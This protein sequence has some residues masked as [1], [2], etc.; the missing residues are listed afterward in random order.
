MTIF[1]ASCNKNADLFAIF[2]HCMEKYWTKHPKVVYSTETIKN[3]YYTTICKDYPLDQWTR[4]IRESLAEIDDDVIL[5]MVDDIFIRKAVDRKRIKFAESLFGGSLAFINLEQEFGECEDVGL[6]GFKR[7]T[8][9][10]FVISLM[11]GLWDREK[12]I[13]IL[14]ADASPWDVEFNADLKD[15]TYYINSGDRII[16]WGH[17]PFE[18]FGLM[19]G[20]W[21]RE[22][23]PFF[24]AEGIEIDYEKRGF[25][26]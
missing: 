15:Y 17:A 22:V 16:D 3:P 21:M 19:Q 7:R 5:F 18:W 2:H 20:K 13:D 8:D 1:V 12:L 11:C 14:S 6:K 23:V 26:D 24:E 10:Y 25:A 4:R 9:G